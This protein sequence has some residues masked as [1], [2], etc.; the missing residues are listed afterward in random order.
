MKPTPTAYHRFTGYDRYAMKP[1]KIA[2]ILFWVGLCGLFLG[3]AF[4]HPPC[5]GALGDAPE[6]VVVTYFY[7]Y[8][9][10]DWE[11]CVECLDPQF[12]I[13]LKLQLINLIKQTEG[14]TQKR[15]LIAFR[16]DNI[17]ELRGIPSKKFYEL[18][19]Q[20][21]WE[22]KNASFAGDFDKAKIRVLSTKKINAEA[23]LVQF[24]ASVNI[25]NGS[26]DRIQEYAVK[27]K[28]KKWKIY[29]TEPLK[30]SEAK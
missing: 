20:D 24:C 25:G 10:K 13:G 18:Y 21:L 23:C 16:V 28:G 17:E 29:S 22:R 8:M 6:D 30:E 19:L 5:A 4:I 7:A 2:A 11:G 14:Y 9:N 15:M 12:L 27:K 3:P 26:Y 1:Q